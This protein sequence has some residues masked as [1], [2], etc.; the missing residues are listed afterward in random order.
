MARILIADPYPDIA[1]LFAQAVSSFGHEPTEDCD[2]DVDA[3]IID[4]DTDVGRALARR[5]S[6]TELPVI[7]V[8][9]HTAT[10]HQIAA[11][12]GN[13]LVKPFPLPQLRAALEHA[14]E[15]SGARLGT[16][17]PVRGDVVALD[18]LE[19]SAMH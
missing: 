10:A 15:R 8:T 7:C 1:H 12:P 2:A 17:A 9:I 18:V 4:I 5:V 16:G 11:S 13:L 19:H 3:A 14:L 6:S